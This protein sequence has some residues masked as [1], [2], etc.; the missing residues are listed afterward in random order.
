MSF[1]VGIPR[2][3]LYY[4]YFP[5]WK[6]FFESLGCEVVVSD[7]SNKGI[8]DTGV[9][10]AVDEACLPVKLAF[11]HVKNLADK[12]VDYI[13]LPR[14]VSVAYREYICPKFLGF[15]DMAKQ[16]ILGLPEV[17]D[18]TISYS[19]SPKNVELAYKQMGKKFCSN[20]IKIWRAYCKGQKALTKYNKLLVE[21]YLPEEAMSVM[22]DKSPKGKPV[23]LFG[24]LNIAL[25]GHPYNIYDPYIN[26][27]II[28]RLRSM[29]AMV[30]TADHLSE[31]EVRQQAA[32]LP[33]KLFWTIGQRMIGAGYHYAES[34]DIDGVIHIAAFACG[35]DSMTGELIERNIRSSTKLPFLNLTLDE[36]T[37]EAG[38]ITRIEAFLDMV[39]WKKSQELTG[40]RNI[41]V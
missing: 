30:V 1:K 18:T 6:E 9:K 3:L 13:F 15:P 38:V 35:P 24:D 14:L 2:A 41:V 17:I 19:R 25:I 26:M 4:Y 36:H 29:G 5:L 39:R 10:N 28:K 31:N 37:G 12:N 40:N 27:N 23:E 11:G 33:K 8:L 21:G 20:P 32:K 22:Y 7:K 16:N 34:D